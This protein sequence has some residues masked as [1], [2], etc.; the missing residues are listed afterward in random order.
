M[1]TDNHQWIRKRVD[2]I[3]NLHPITRSCHMQCISSEE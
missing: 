2:F 3:A 1:T